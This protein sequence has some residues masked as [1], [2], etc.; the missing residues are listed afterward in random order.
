MSKIK[1]IGIGFLIT[2]LVACLG[3]DVWYLYVK[4]FGPKKKVSHTYEVGLQTTT[5]G[6]EKYF[7][8]VNYFANETGDGVELFEIKFNYLLDENKEKFFSQG[9]QYVNSNN[10]IEFNEAVDK[11][12]VSYKQNVFGWE[13]FKYDCIY[14]FELSS[15][16]NR[17]N[18]MSYD[19]YKNT[20][21]ST[22]PI[23][24]ET[25][26]K[27]DINGKIYGMQFRGNVAQMDS[28]QKYDAGYW[29]TGSY[30]DFVR[31][32][33]DYLAGLIFN[34][35]SSL[36]AGTSSACVFEFG[37]LFDYYEYNETEQAY[38]D[39]KIDLDKATI[40]SEDIKSYYS[41]LVNKYSNGA[42]KSSESLFNCID[43]NSGFNL[44]DIESE[45]YFY[46]RTG[47]T[48]NNYAFKKVV[49]TDNSVALKLKNEFVKTFE[50]YDELV[51]LQVLIDL[52]ELKSMGFEFVGFT[53]DSGLD[54]FEI[55]SCQTVETVDGQ[56][57][58]TEVSYVS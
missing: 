3:I 26:F 10:S 45:D 25:F 11:Q 31:Y 50:K 29:N 47:I 53:A 7:A 17:H 32:D 38:L 14:T 46:G 40:V 57:V 39:K 44:T 2:L 42:K 27:I 15:G 18:Y 54:K 20:L 36:K 24:D 22:N 37:N 55:I 4:K 16:T 34:G 35:L 5:D 9:L 28:Y 56:L 8:E 43:G 52:D 30:K 58:Y 23:G 21:K 1:G 49:I 19:D 48:A 51:Q 33:V 12:Q 41:I 6:T 13:T